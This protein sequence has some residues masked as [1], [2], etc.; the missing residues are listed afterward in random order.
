MTGNFS[1]CLLCFGDHEPE[2]C[3]GIEAAR[4]AAQRRLA[5]RPG[6]AEW[7]RDRAA[8]TVNSSKTVTESDCF[9]RIAEVIEHAAL[10]LDEVIRQRDD[11]VSQQKRQSACG[12]PLHQLSG[13]AQQLTEA[14]AM[15]QRINALRLKAEAAAAGSEKAKLEAEQH[16][17]RL[18]TER[19][20]LKA[21]RDRAVAEIGYSG[22]P[23]P[24]GSWMQ[25]LELAE[26]QRDRLAEALR[27]YETVLADGPENC[28]WSQYEECHNQARPILAEVEGK[29]GA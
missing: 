16:A 28:S 4:A 24:G 20:A 23:P 18:R 3:P 14:K 11:A 7:Y 29:E 1:H 6:S 27:Q 19:D 17:K 13:T 22:S 5:L 21:E 9:S 25:R 12:S 10:Q 15:I 2:D 26:R 8:E